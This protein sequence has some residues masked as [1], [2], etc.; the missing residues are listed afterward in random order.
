MPIYEYQ[1][2]AC[3][4]TFTEIVRS[5]EDRPASPSC[6]QCDAAE[7]HRVI[8]APSVVTTER[9]SEDGS[10]QGDRQQAQQANRQ[11]LNEALRKV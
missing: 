11:D 9:E 1:C 6:P 5:P 3:N 8:S 7:T 2:E 4:H 10:E